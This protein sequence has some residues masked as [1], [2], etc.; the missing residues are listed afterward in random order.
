M[1]SAM[2]KEQMTILELAE[3]LGIAK[4]TVQ[5]YLQEAGNPRADTIELIYDNLGYPLEELLNKQD[6][7]PDSEPPDFRS[8]VEHFE[9][10]HPLLKPV[11]FHSFHMAQDMIK[12]SDLLYKLDNVQS[13]N[14]S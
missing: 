5:L 7:P 2:T 4:S 13:D 10:I 14:E 6:I 8:L 9:V 3:K 11:V 1:R 12:L